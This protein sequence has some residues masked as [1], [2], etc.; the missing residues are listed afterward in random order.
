[1]KELHSRAAWAASLSSFIDTQL[2]KEDIKDR[3]NPLQATNDSEMANFIINIVCNSILIC[4]CIFLGVLFSGHVDMRKIVGEN[5]E[6][7]R[8]VFLF[9][10]IIGNSICVMKVIPAFVCMI[11]I[12][13]SVHILGILDDEPCSDDLTQESIRNAY[14]YQPKALGM[15]I[16]AMI[17]DAA[18]ILLTVNTARKLSYFAANYKP[19]DQNKQYEE[20]PDDDVIS[21]LRV[22]NAL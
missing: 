5:V 15:N 16:A 20:I 22:E 17:L 21:P 18:Q 4:I 7:E 19:G 6:E 10:S 9:Q 2:L 11:V 1:M 12:S 14:K 3:M 13:R 8:Y